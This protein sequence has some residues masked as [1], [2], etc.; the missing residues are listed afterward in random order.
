MPFWLA[1]PDNVSPDLMVCSVLFPEGLLML[2]ILFELPEIDAQATRRT[3]HSSTSPGARFTALVA[4]VSDWPQTRRRSYPMV[5][6]GLS[7]ISNRSE[8]PTCFSNE[9]GTMPHP[10][11]PTF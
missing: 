4:F 2:L 8:Q 9:L 5:S 10:G 11:Q 3:T 6:D 1:I 7:Y